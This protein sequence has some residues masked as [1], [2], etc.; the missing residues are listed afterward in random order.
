ML[1]I[2]L[3]KIL[4]NFQCQKI[5][6]T[7]LTFNYFHLEDTL[8]VFCVTFVSLLKELLDDRELIFLQKTKVIS[9]TKI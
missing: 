4:Q 3:K 6:I 8:L 1:E 2:I 9:Q 5:N 7:L